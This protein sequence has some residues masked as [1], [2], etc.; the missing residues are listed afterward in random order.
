MEEITKRFDPEANLQHSNSVN[1]F[2]AH[3]GVRGM[4]WGVRRSVGSGGHV[5]GPS[6]SQVS[7][8]AKMGAKP[9]WQ[10]TPNK[11]AS[12]PVVSL[13]KGSLNKGKNQKTISEDTQQFR[14]IR[15]KVKR[16]GVNSLS[17]K[18]LEVINKRVDLQQK[19]NKA[20]PKKKSPFGLAADLVIDAVL[21]E[22]GE[23]H[24]GE[25]IGPRSPDTMVMVRNA[26][27]LGRTTKTI[28]KK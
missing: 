26:L 16:E 25:F 10:S 21:T 28:T 15:A 7:G 5:V 22:A 8:S 20:F 9:A 23:R 18:E 14:D 1:E 2:I 19:Y 13:K 11:K 24:L 4:H 3:Y 6:K 17:N 27:L 12:L